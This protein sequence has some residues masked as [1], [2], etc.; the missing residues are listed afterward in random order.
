MIKLSGVTKLLLILVAVIGVLVGLQFLSSGRVSILNDGAVSALSPEVESV[1]AAQEEDN[2]QPA[3]VNNMDS[4]QEM[5]GAPSSLKKDTLEPSEL[6]P[7]KVGEW[8]SA[9]PA[10]SNA[11]KGKNFL[12]SGHH[13]GVNTVGQ[14]LRNANMQ[15][16]SEPPNPQVKVSPWQQ[17]TIE[18]DVNRKPMEIG[19]CA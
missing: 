6:L 2:E 15:L 18:P 3:P 19:G 8:A 7:S 12:Q 17:S 9:Y 11:L 4:M 14:T 16:R 5:D 10:A 1:N 13:V